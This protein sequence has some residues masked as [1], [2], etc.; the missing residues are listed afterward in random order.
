MVWLIAILCLLC[1]LAALTVAGIVIYVYYLKL[2]KKRASDL[3]VYNEFAEEDGIVFL[4]D[5]LTDFFPASEFFSCGK[6]YNRGIAGNTTADVKA[7]LNDVIDLNPRRIILQIGVNDMIYGSKK[8]SAR[9]IC[10]RIFDIADRLTFTE[11]F[12]VSLYPVNRRKTFLSGIICRHAVNG[13]ID[14]VNRLLREK[15]AATGITFVDINSALKDDEGNLDKQ[16]TLEGL[17]LSAK[18]NCVVAENLKSALDIF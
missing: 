12:I 1:A 13:K 11:L 10:D 3:V 9:E 7:R 5:S 17:H 8:L 6:V 16:Y 2:L 15:C 14:E 18:G 4:G